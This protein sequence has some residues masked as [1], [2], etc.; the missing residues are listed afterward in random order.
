M[1]R[2]K[3]PVRQLSRSRG[4][5]CRQSLHI[6][7]GALL[8]EVEMLHG[9]PNDQSTVHTL[10]PNDSVVIRLPGVCHPVLSN[11]ATV[12]V[13]GGSLPLTAYVWAEFENNPNEIAAEG[14]SNP[15]IVPISR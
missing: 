7:G 8:S 11:S 3:T 14:R 9:N 2:S 4:R 12:L 13:V 1:W 5:S 15:I 6:D 10:L